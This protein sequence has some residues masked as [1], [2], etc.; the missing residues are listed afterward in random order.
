MLLSLSCAATILVNLSGDPWNKHD[1][2]VRKR[3][4]YVCA[5]D[6]RYKDTPC[7]YKLV[8]TKPRSFQAFCGEENES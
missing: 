4:V 5:N 8:K 2:K 7:L 6:P 3:A 1:E